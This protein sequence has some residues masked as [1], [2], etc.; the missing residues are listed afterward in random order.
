MPCE[1]KVH[2]EILDQDQEDSRSNTSIKRRIKYP[3]TV[4]LSLSLS[5]TKHHLKIHFP[6]ITNRIR[7]RPQI[8][9]LRIRPP[10]LRRTIP[11]KTSLTHTTLRTPFP[12]RQRINSNSN[13]RIRSRHDRS[14]ICCSSQILSRVRNIRVAEFEKCLRVPLAGC[15]PFGVAG[16]THAG[17]EVGGGDGGGGFGGD[18]YGRGFLEHG[19]GRGDLVEGELFGKGTVVVDLDLEGV[20]VGAGGEGGVIIIMIMIII[21]GAA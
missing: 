20:G 15:A 10:L 9:L 18:V 13:I 12:I 14:I 4:S 6:L 7:R 17:F 16:E 1:K 5:R 21:T 19:E 2:R 11:R 3:L 8:H